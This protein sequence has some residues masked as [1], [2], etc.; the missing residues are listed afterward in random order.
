MK[1]WSK[2]I[3]VISLGVV[4]ALTGCNKGGDGNVDNENKVTLSVYCVKDHPYYKTAINQFESVYESMCDVDLKEFESD[5]AMNER[6]AGELLSGDGPD[7]VLLNAATEFDTFKTVQSGKLED[8]QPYMKE[9]GSF[10]EENYYMSIVDGG[11][12]QDAQFIIP[13][14][15]SLDLILTNQNI[16]KYDQDTKHTYTTQELFQVMNEI[17]DEQGEEKIPCALFSNGLYQTQIAH[18]VE[19]SGIPIIDE[20]K[21]EVVLEKERCEEIYNF[22]KRMNEVSNKWKDSLIQVRNLGQLGEIS[23][24][25]EASGNC[26]VNA[27]SWESII[28]E[29]NNAQPVIIPWTNG[30]GKPQPVINDFGFINAASKHKEQSFWLIRFLTKYTIPT[31]V[32]YGI[33]VSKEVT[34]KNL[35]GMSENAGK[36]LS[37]KNEKKITVLPMSGE[38]KEDMDNMLKNMDSAVLGNTGYH[39]IVSDVMTEG[40]KKDREFPDVY[41]DTVDQLERYLAE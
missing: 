27:R 8:L 32:D 14:S 31:G 37:L 22:L 12:F 13:F 30:E 10:N 9:D 40:L 2:K 1:Q 5:A 7:V 20:E 38:V 18:F 11:K 15:F 3:A 4:C 24:L 21:K 6:L 19:Y 16:W 34:T 35:A 28:K 25:V 36:E 29:I 33:S 23:S 26:L 17:I 39:K 41:Q